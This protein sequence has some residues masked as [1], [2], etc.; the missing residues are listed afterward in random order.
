MPLVVIVL[1]AVIVVGALIY[2]AY[3]ADKRRKEL[4][5]WAAR[6]GLEFSAGNVEDL[7]ERYSDFECL[8]EGSN[9]YA[10]N[11]SDGEWAK[12]P[13]LAFDYHYETYST[14]SKGR[15]Q[16]HHHRFSAAVIT[17]AVPLKPL[18]IRPEGF[19]DKVGEFFGR[20]DIN[21]ESAEFSRKFFVKAPDRKWA[22][23]VLH[24][25][26]IEFLLPRPQFHIQFD[27]ECV[28]IFRNDM[29]SVEDFQSAVETVA[30]ILDR[31]PDYLVQQ[32]MSTTV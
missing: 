11:V 26:T 21:F 6:N 13:L 17:S 23:D 2:N 15:R 10:Y 14:D 31:L 18:S 29:F 27:E 12:R 20:E 7:D 4:A 28:I 30:G 8:C 19:L 32:Q 22:F 16:T 24:Q 9:R 5:A 3:A 25:R 1:F